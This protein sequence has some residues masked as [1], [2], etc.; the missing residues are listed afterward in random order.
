MEEE[1]DDVFI[2]ETNG[3]LPQEPA[4][5]PSRHIKPTRS[6][7]EAGDPEAAMLVTNGSG[8]RKGMGD[9]WIHSSIVDAGAAPSQ[10]Q[11]WPRAINFDFLT[12]LNYYMDQLS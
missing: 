11:K 1:R 6:D 5:A 12:R 8:S 9:S 3:G 2:G 7:V 10:N 4:Q